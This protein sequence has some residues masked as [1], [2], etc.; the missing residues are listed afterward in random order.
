MAA[1]APRTPHVSLEEMCAALREH[2]Q[3]H[4]AAEALGMQAPNFHRAWARRRHLAGLPEQTPL[5]YM[6]ELGVA[7][8]PTGT[9]P[10]LA[11]HFRLRPLLEEAAEAEGEKPTELAKRILTE[12]LTRW[13]RRT[14]R[15]AP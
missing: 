6:R 3:V 8:E 2:G 4:A 10:L 15:P 9:Q 5:E 12:W 7:P 14:G 11:F 1:G 13:A